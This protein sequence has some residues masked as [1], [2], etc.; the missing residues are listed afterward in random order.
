[1]LKL[2]PNK[3]VLLAIAVLI[4]T[5]VVLWQASKPA[6]SKALPTKDDRLDS[7]L[8]KLA[9]AEAKSHKHH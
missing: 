1:M 2:L 6:S 4:T 5:Y 8:A 9:G 7:L 3:W